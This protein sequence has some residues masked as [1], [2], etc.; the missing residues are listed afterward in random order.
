MT[1]WVFLFKNIRDRVFA[2]MTKEAI[3]LSDHFTYKKIIKFT[4]GTILMMIFSSIYWIVDGFFISNY[5]GTSA[6]A[7]VNLIFPVIMA[8]ACI[9]F[10]FGAGGAALVSKKLGE[11]KE[12]E[13]NKTFS[14]ITCFTLI[15]GLIFSLVFFFLVRP[16]AQGFASINT[17]NATEEMIDNAV[18]YGR[19]MIGGVS[20]YIM[21]SFFHSFFAVN[22]RND[23]GFL[24]TFASGVINM[25]LDYILIGVVGMQ[26]EGAAIAS[27]CGMSISA[28]GP[29][30]Y[31]Y[32]SKKSLIHL[33]KPHFSI[34]D[35]TKSL[36]NGFS[37]FVSNVSGS[38]ISIVFNVQ[39]IK[40]IGESG[41]AAYGVIGYVC[42]VF[43]AIFIGYSV[44]ITP[45]IGYN[46]GAKN[47]KEL[48]NILR[49]SFVIIEIVGIVM[50][51]LAI[52]FARP[53]AEIF[54]AGNS[55][56]QDLSVHA[57]IIFSFCYLFT[58]YSMF[59][60]SF[61]TALNNG[62][63]SAIISFCRTL[64]FQL[65]AVFVLPLIFGIDG[66]WAS[67][68]VAEVLSMVMTIIFMIIYQKRYGYSLDPFRIKERR[69]K[70][71]SS[72]V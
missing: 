55:E 65:I 58:G 4:L 69:E 29:S 37:E 15:T 57:M 66:I 31:F 3:H 8:V 25:L 9:G 54:T 13:A 21:Q 30:L 14:L 34:S 24:F 43:F 63:I 51:A 60:S 64:V 32:L 12:E 33:C 35:I 27:L 45:V 5:I 19:I 11:K 18:R 72:D 44:A 49:K 56:L 61:F 7:G 53:I 52:G 38:V 48:S 17:V 16:I 6:F 22:E 71:T 46:Y 23:L 10:M 41:V 59:G 28:I 20:L 2:A 1:L 42:F 36:T 70:M 68:V 47:G 62:L 40:Y 39:L 67:I 26:I 50:L